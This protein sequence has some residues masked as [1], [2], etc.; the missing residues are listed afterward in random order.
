MFVREAYGA[1]FFKVKVQQMPID[2]TEVGA[3]YFGPVFS[4]F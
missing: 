2:G 3:F 1:E 4:F